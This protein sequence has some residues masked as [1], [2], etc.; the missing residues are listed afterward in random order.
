MTKWE[1][2]SLSPVVC[3]RVY[4]LFTL[5]VFAYVLW[6]PKHIVL[7]I[8][9]VFLRPVCLVYAMPFLIAIS[10][11]SNVYLKDIRKTPRIYSAW[12]KVSHQNGRQ[13]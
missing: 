8:C 3:R 5:F 9:F 13:K 1:M 12:P 6:C 2:L 4:V 11:F 10:F 7:F